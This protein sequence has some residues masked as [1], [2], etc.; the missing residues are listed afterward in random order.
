M[1]DVRGSARGIGTIVVDIRFPMAISQ[2]GERNTQV[3]RRP[4]GHGADIPI[5]TQTAR[6]DHVLG[7]F[8]RQR[9]RFVP[10]SVRWPP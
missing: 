4:I 1:R 3:A 6:N 7:D 2:G 5:R 9:S 10:R 8:S